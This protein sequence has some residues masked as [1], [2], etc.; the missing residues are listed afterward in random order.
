MK[1]I[2]KLIVIGFMAL[3]FGS[4]KDYLD[5]RPKTSLSEKDFFTSEQGFLQAL[6]GVYS[7]MASRN[8][9]TD[10]LSMGYVS[11]MAQNY[12]P[13]TADA[14]LP[15]NMAPATLGH[16]TDA[17][18]AHAS[19]VWTS[20]YSAIANLNKIIENTTLNRAVL[21]ENNAYALVRGEAL[22]LRALLHFDLYRLFGKEYV[23]NTNAK[24]IPYRMEVN[25]FA[26]PP[27]TSE[28]VINFVLADLK[29]AEDLLEATDPIVT[30]VTSAAF[31][32]VLYRREN[33]NYYGIKA[34]EARVRITMGDKVGAAAAANVVI[35]SNLYP[36]VTAAAASASANRDRLYITEQIFML[37][38][39]NMTHADGNG[40]S[41]FRTGGL[42]GSKLTRSSADFSTLF[43]TANGGTSDY[44]FA[45]RI[46]SDG[47]SV[48]PSKFWQNAS[49]TLGQDRLDQYV[50]VIRLAEMYYILAE[51]ATTPEEGIAF[52]NTVRSYRGLLPLIPNGTAA[53][54]TAELLKEYQKEFHAEGQLFFYYKRTNATTMQFKAAPTTIAPAQ[55]VVPIPDLELQY[56][57]TY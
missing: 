30:K 54:L 4:C 12:S 34:L 15:N 37:R 28:E 6:N 32:D 57:P 48:Y 46:E 55:Y 51:T 13:T 41:Y 29:E 22:A 24:A 3:A 38:S 11:A 16:T 44:R 39:S 18:K 35:A 19:A 20:A 7:Q 14:S 49:T 2:I 36:F 53:Q 5:V 56:N 45:Y 1:E 43:E 40:N 17:E 25:E 31:P 23:A 10:K 27:S 21:N 52:L 26:I 50:P 47:G 9:Y 42:V 33:L 8:L